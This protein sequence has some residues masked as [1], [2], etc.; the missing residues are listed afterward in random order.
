MSRAQQ[1]A[2]SHQPLLPRGHSS[3]L[4]DRRLSQSCKSLAPSHVWNFSAKTEVDK[5]APDNTHTHTHTSTSLRIAS[6]A[7][8]SPVSDL[9]C[10]EGLLPSSIR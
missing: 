7:L 1:K 8:L 2:R 4:I 5:E 6:R 9:W 10:P 3:A